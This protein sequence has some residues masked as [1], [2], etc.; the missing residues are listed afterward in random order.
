VPSC[1]LLFGLAPDGVTRVELVLSDG[2]RSG[3]VVGNVA[4]IPFA[5]DPSDVSETRWLAADGT[6]IA[7][8]QE[9]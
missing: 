7:R 5:G 6:V 9:R 1:V 8:S 2:R 4:A 3:A